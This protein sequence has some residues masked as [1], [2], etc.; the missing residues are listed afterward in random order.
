MRVEDGSAAAD[1][2]EV[3]REWNKDRRADVGNDTF[4]SLTKEMR[5]WAIKESF[6]RRNTASCSCLLRRGRTSDGLGTV[7]CDCLEI[8]GASSDIR[9][10]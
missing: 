2:E 9:R 4:G 7:V 10:A 5:A 1:K 6:E 8:P 3:P